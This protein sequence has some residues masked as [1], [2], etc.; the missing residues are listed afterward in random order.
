MFHTI[1][2]VPWHTHTH[3]HTHV[4]LY[5]EPQQDSRSVVST[6]SVHD[7]KPCPEC[8]PRQAHTP[9]IYSP[10]I[11]ECRTCVIVTVYECRTQLTNAHPYMPTHIHARRAQKKTVE[12]ISKK[13]PSVGE[14]VIERAIGRSIDT[15]I[16]RSSKRS[17]DRER[18]IE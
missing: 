17:S 9:C 1:E 7:I 13:N 6:F 2:H 3:T 18:A 15:A 16:G 4:T 5:I 14:R 10:W 11:C 8:S 12:T